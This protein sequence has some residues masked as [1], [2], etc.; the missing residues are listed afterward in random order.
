MGPAGEDGDANNDRH[1]SIKTL[2]I[3][4]ETPP[5]VNP[6]EFRP[7]RSS[8]GWYFNTDSISVLDPKYLVDFIVGEIRSLLG[9]G[10]ATWFSYGKLLYEHI[11]TVTVRQDGEEIERFDVAERL[12][13]F[14]GYSPARI[15][16]M[17]YEGYKAIAW[18]RRASRG[19]KG[20]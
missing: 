10:D 9:S 20:R 2:D 4:V 6:E 18:K 15:T 12:K 19:L 1:I 17:S 16:M 11:D 3:N 13:D 5:G 8:G 14:G 7:P